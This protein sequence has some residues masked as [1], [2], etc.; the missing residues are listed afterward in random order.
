M[1]KLCP[2]YGQEI[3]PVDVDYVGYLT[4]WLEKYCSS[5]WRYG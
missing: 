4:F 3:T 5:E 1:K 2:D